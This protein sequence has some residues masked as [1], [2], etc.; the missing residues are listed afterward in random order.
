LIDGKSIDEMSRN[1]V[2]AMRRSVGYVFQGAAL[3]DSLSVFDNVVIGLVE[4][5]VHDRSMLENEGRRV[6]SAVGLLPGFE[7]S[8]TPDY[9]REFSILAQKRPS[10]LSGGMR[11][12]VGVARALV[13]KPSYIFYDEP[14]TGLDPVTSQQ[15]DDML[16]YVA[17]SLDVTSVVITHDMFSVYNV[18]DYV[19]MLHEGKV[20][21][22]GTV[23]ELRTSKDPIVVEFLERFEPSVAL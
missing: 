15:I 14:T 12:R 6:L 11:K 16:S 20:Q 3:F 8:G 4:H 1:D 13:G 7:L 5:G 23:D 18:A 17:E 9:E 2:Y 22:D 10:D 21:F 19:I